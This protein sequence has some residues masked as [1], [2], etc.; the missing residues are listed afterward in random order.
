MIGWLLS[1]IAGFADLIIA[2]ILGTITFFL[3]VAIAWIRY[4]PMI[5]FT[6]LAVIFAI[7]IVVAIED[8]TAS[9]KIS[10]GI[11]SNSTSIAN[12]TLNSTINSTTS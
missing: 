2:L 8:L 5:G 4:R 7:I 1:D 3:V 10:S 12:F 11:N 9:S 6:F